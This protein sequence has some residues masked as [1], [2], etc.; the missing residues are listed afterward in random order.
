MARLSIYS[1]PIFMFDLRRHSRTKPDQPN[2][3]GGNKIDKAKRQASTTSRS[4][5]LDQTLPWPHIRAWSGSPLEADIGA[6]IRAARHQ[7]SFSPFK[8]ACPFLPTI[9]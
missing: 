4:A 7:I 8:L 3:T 6:H 2:L 9:M 5:K 1:S